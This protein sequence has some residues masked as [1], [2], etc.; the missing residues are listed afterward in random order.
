MDLDA[1]C[2]GDGDNAMAAILE[3]V[4][5]GRDFSGI[6]NILARGDD[7]NDVEKEL[8]HDMSSLPFLDREL[9]YRD[10]P[11]LM[12]QGIRSFQ[13]Q[14]GC[15]FQCSYCFNHSFN[16]MFK[17]EMKGPGRGL[18]RRRS[19]DHLF[20]EIKYVTENFPEARILRF[21]D[22]VFL[23]RK[24]EWLEEFCARYPKEIGLPF[25][26]LVRPDSLTEEVAK[27]LS[28][29]GCTSIGMSIESGDELIRRKLIKRPVS[30]EVMKRAFHLTH[31][32]NLPAFASTIMGIPGTTLEDDFNSF[33]YAKK[34]KPAA[35]TFAI[36]SP[37]AQ[38][39]LTRIAVEKGLL[40]N[41][42]SLTATYR[43][44]SQLNCYTEKEKEMQQ[45]LCYLAPLFCYLPDF[46]IPI[47]KMLMRLSLSSRTG[48]YLT[49]LC[50]FIEATFSTYV[51]GSKIF[52]QSIP[53]KPIYF[54]KIGWRSVKYFLNSVRNQDTKQELLADNIQKIGSGA[55]STCD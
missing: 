2:I 38:T 48:A 45:R 46:M 44:K 54:V 22:D 51:V 37:F 18:M 39:E 25:Y 43:S 20:E 24:D 8:V 35:P 27:M 7:V 11:D 29:A 1:I 49:R 34:L 41:G 40:D 17:Q 36:F 26:C 5:S 23:V 52:P 30:D 16:Q 15:P 55:V 50:G 3:R 42:D 10:S 4:E 53:K 9:L 21:A 28:D 33:L 6:P 31:K 19:V 47:L 32:Y 14:R 13:T 12:Q